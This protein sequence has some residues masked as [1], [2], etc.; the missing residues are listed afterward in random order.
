[1][2]LNAVVVLCLS[3]LATAAPGTQDAPPALENLERRAPVQVLAIKND[4]NEFTA[5]V[6][7]AGN[8]LAAAINLAYQLTGS[9]A[10][11]LK[12]QLNELRDIFRATKGKANTVMSYI[13]EVYGV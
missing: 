13:G 6:T 10:D 9:S 4:L 2:K 12:T 7:A 1:M 8:D 3:A 5:G 11:G